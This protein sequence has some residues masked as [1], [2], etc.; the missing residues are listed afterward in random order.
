MKKVIHV[1]HG[2]IFLKKKYNID[3]SRVELS[4]EFCDHPVFNPGGYNYDHAISS[5]KVVFVYV[6]SNWFTNYDDALPH[7]WPR[8]GAI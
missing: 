8:G 4:Y 6:Y 2:K 1:K 5:K 3:I 7:A